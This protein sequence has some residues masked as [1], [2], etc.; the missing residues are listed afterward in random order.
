MVKYER[1]VKR[2]RKAHQVYLVLAVCQTIIS[3]L[4]RDVSSQQAVPEGQVA[5]EA[6]TNQSAPPHCLQSMFMGC[7]CN[8]R[9]TSD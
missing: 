7:R 6:D 4:H 2:S 5:D 3:N 8:N 1:R 9:L